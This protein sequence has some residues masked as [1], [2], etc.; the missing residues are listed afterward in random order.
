MLILVDEVLDQISRGD[1]AD[2]FASINDWKRVKVVTCK[3]ARRVSNG[4]AHRNGNWLSIRQIG[5]LVS[6]VENCVKT[7]TVLVAEVSKS[8]SKNV[9]PTD[10]AYKVIAI[11]DWQVVTVS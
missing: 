9:I 11:D 5:Q 2:E 4:A 7:A 6:V 10:D 3:L 1:D 8:D